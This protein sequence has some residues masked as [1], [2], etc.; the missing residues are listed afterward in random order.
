M[1]PLPPIRR[2]LIVSWDQTAAFRRFTQDFGS[3]W[4]WRT[5]SVGGPHVARLVF[6]CRTGGLIFEEHADGRRFQWG[7][8]LEWEPPRRLKFSWHPAREPS[9][10]QEVEVRFLP[11][12]SGTRVEL[13]SDHWEN[14]GRNAQRARKG[15]DMGWAYVLNVWAGRRT[16]GM[17][18][19]DGLALALRGVEWLRGGP[20]ASIAR[21]GGEIGPAQ[22]EGARGATT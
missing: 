7:R 22:R 20:R 8:V 1:T 17:A 10:A 13:V 5:H 15:Y 3:W 21:A 11:E 18:V 6:E 14:W 19:L 2:S 12:G 9:T 16:L 4:P